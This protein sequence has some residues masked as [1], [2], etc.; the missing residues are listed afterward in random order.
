MKINSWPLDLELWFCL[1]RGR[2]SQTICFS[3]VNE[4][5][6]AGA[7]SSVRHDLSLH[8]NAP[9]IVFTL[10]QLEGEEAMFVCGVESEKEYVYSPRRLLRDSVA[11][12]NAKYDFS[13]SRFL[14]SWITVCSNEQGGLGTGL[15]Y[16][17]C[18]LSHWWFTECIVGATLKMDI[19][20]Q[21]HSF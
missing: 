11:V 3:P 21:W 6:K 9:R 13:S 1:L 4:S 15:V 12:V 19:S 8:F 5:T 18:T 10:I 17:S 14:S 16:W 2:P 7:I 20:D